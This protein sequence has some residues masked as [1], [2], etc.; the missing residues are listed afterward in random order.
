MAYKIINFSDNISNMIQSSI[1][2][3]KKILAHFLVLNIPFSFIVLLD[4]LGG[5][6]CS[7]PHPEYT[8]ISFNAVIP[9]NIF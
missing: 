9:I 2:E 7:G 6:L 4:I 5:L 1:Y 8:L 3:L